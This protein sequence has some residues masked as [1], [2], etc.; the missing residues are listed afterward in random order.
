MRS[1]ELNKLLRRAEA[2]GVLFMPRAAL[3]SAFPAE[4]E[5]AFERALHRHIADGLI[6]RPARGLYASP[7]ARIEPRC[8]W[9]AFVSALRPL[10][11][12]YLSLEYRLSELGCISQVA[13][14]VTLVTTGKKGAYATP[15]GQVELATRL[16][17]APSGTL[18]WDKARD[19]WIASPR[20]ALDDLVALHRPS[21]DLVDLDEVE[22]AERAF[23]NQAEASRAA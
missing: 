15:Y 17:Q 6:D 11:S 8:P 21:V 12:W 20:R 19:C 14:T 22:E 7:R 13:Q 10:E 2:Q 5:M 3:R 4:G 18:A 16:A 1:S 9:S 23:Q